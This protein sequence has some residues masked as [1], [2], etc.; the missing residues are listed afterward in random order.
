M[1]TPSRTQVTPSGTGMRVHVDDTVVEV[2]DHAKQGA[3]F[4]YNRIRGLDA[5][6]ATLN[7]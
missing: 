6:L 7:R 3:R 4:G 5:L 2:H 1:L